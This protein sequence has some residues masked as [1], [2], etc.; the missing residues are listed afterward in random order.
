MLTWG[1]WLIFIL[2]LLSLLNIKYNKIFRILGWFMTTKMLFVFSYYSWVEQ[3]SLVQ[4]GLSLMSGVLTLFILYFIIKDKIS[5]KHL[6]IFIT[7]SSGLLLLFYTISVAQ[8]TLIKHVAGG[9][10]LFIELIGYDVILEPSENGMYIVFLENNLRTEIIMACTGIGSIALFTGFIS[11]LD[12]LSLQMKIILISISSGLIY[13]L[14][15]IRNVFIAGAYGGQWF[16]IYPEYVGMIFGRSDD[17]VSFY[18][19]DRI[20][21]Q[22]G[23]VIVMILFTIGIINILNEETKL[24]N[25]CVDIID[26]IKNYL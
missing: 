1:G 25:E 18:I 26:N 16:H 8:T 24:I 20:I 21:S 19:A 4:S 13:I 15:I 14:N 22:I 6:S 23:A 12:T 3:Q 2:L 9:T 17:W 5:V 11:S 7:I 10:S